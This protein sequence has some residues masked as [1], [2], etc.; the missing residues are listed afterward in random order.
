MKMPSGTSTALLVRG[1]QTEMIELAK[2]ALIA[3]PKDEREV[4]C[5]TMSVSSQGME[6]VKAALKEC[7][8]RVLE[9]VQSD[10]G[11]DRVVQMNVQVFP[12]THPKATHAQA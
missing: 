6:R 11:E 5:M 12:I 9:I 8:Q 3:V 2:Q 7:R 10:H 1:F 4:S